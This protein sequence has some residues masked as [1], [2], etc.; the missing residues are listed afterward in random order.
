M[1]SGNKDGRNAVSG[2]V[3]KQVLA[4]TWCHEVPKQSRRRLGVHGR[5]LPFHLRTHLV[6]PLEEAHRLAVGQDERVVSRLRFL[7]PAF[8]RLEPVEVDV[9]PILRT[10]RAVC[11]GGQPLQGRPRERLATRQVPASCTGGDKTESGS[12][13][14]FLASRGKDPMRP[15]GPWWPARAWTPVRRPPG[16]LRAEARGAGPRHGRASRRTVATRPAPRA[17]TCACPPAAR[18]CRPAGAGCGPRPP[19]RRR[20]RR[21]ARACAAPRRWRAPARL[22]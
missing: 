3:G 11:P 21:A 2:Q 12:E 14:R 10:G 22:A 18:R 5:C 17:R 7:H 6:E 13:I 1:A 16:D 9:R 20:A 19:R 15:A 8:A 4:R